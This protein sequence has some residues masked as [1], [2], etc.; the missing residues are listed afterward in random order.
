MS[1]RYAEDPGA[2]PAKLTVRTSAR[3]R[4]A[5]T[6]DGSMSSILTRPMRTAPRAPAD[7]ERAATRPKAR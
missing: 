2:W 1:L 4:C 6:N 3:R 5:G 7:A